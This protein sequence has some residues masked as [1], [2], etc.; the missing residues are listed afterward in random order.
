L[1]EADFFS[2]ESGD[3]ARSHR[4]TESEL[5]ESVIRDV[6][7]VCKTQS[8]FDTLPYTYVSQSHSHQI[9]AAI[10]DLSVGYSSS[11]V[12][13]FIVF[14]LCFFLS[15]YDT[16]DAVI[17]ELYLEIDNCSLRI[18]RKDVLN[19]EDVV[20]EILIMLSELQKRHAVG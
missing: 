10:T 5:V 2:R 6:D 18:D 14:F 15:L 7:F 19:V 9:S 17:I 11:F 20:T 12:S 13:V 1:I 3:V 8:D 4:R 16:F